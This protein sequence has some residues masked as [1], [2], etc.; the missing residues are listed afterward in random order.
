VV[1]G[2]ARARVGRPRRR[3]DPSESHQTLIAQCDTKLWDEDLTDDGN[4]FAANDYELC[5]GE[6]SAYARVL[7]V[8]D[9]EIPE[10]A[11]TTKHFFARL[12]ARLVTFRAHSS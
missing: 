10:G 6:V 11:A 9:Y 5:L 7:G 12:D 4:P 1:G 3:G 2:G 8:G